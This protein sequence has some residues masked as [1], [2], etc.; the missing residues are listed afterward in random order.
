[1][2]FDSCIAANG[3]KFQSRAM[4]L[5][6]VQQCPI[7]NLSE[8]FSYTVK[9]SDFMFLDRF[10]LLDQLLFELLVSCKKYRNTETWK[11]R[12]NHTQ[13]LY[14]CFVKTQ[15]LIYQSLLK[16]GK[17]LLSSRASVSACSVQVKCLSICIP[18]NL[19]ESFCSS[20]IPLIV[21][22]NIRAHLHRQL[23]INITLD[24]FR[25]SSSFIGLNHDWIWLM[26]FRRLSSA[27]VWL[28]PLKALLL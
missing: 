17:S 28:K 20:F 7:S 27:T 25:F 9:C 23:P 1:M 22:L 21:M 18:R 26:V 13:T 14:L 3:E 6:L 8:I 4:T 24:F 10:M 5:T 11:H 19:L 16:R 12:N 15:L 2:G